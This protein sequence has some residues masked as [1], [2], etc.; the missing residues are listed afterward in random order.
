MET[1]KVSRSEKVR[2]WFRKRSRSVDKSSMGNNSLLGAKDSSRPTNLKGSGSL[3]D[4]DSIASGQSCADSQSIINQDEAPVLSP[5]MAAEVATEGVAATGMMTPLRSERDPWRQ[6]TGYLNDDDRTLLESIHAHDNADRVLADLQE[7]IAQKEKISREKAWKITFSGRRILIRDLLSKIVKW[8][9]SFKAIG[10]IVSQIDPVHAGIPWSAVKLVLSV[11]TADQEQMGLIVVGLEQVV[12]L[13]S[14]CSIYHQLYL[15]NPVQTTVSQS[16]AIKKLSDAMAYL[17]A[18]IFAFLA[19][20]IRLTDINTGARILKAF[21]QPGEVSERLKEIATLETRVTTEANLCEGTS[22]Q[23]VLQRL[24]D[25]SQDTR[26]K[27]KN[28][29]SQFDGAM[30]GLWKQLNEEERC[31][32]LQWV[33]DIPHESDH[34]VARK[35]RVDGTGDWLI[36]HEVYTTW[37]ESK[38][39]ALLWL[40][41]IPGAGK[42]KL[43]SRVID[44]LLTTLPCEPG[45]N[46]GFAYFYCDRNRADH[47]EPVA[48]MR[49]LVRQLC[50]P[51]DHPSIES[52]VEDQYLKRKVKGFS[53]DR[54]VA[55]DCKQLLLQLVA[56]YHCVYIVVDGLDECDRG[57]RHILMD[58]LDEMVE[59]FE[60]SVKIYIASRTDQD[61]RNRYHNGT[62]LEVTA[63]D[64]QAD[65]EKYILKKMEQSN[66][67]QKRLY[68]KLRRKILRTFQ[69]KS[70]GMFQWATLHIGELLQLERNADIANYLDG[71]PK[72]LEAAY[73]KIY[74]QISNQIGSKRDIAFA[75]FKVVMA[76]R[77]PLH[78]F[79]LAIAVAQHPSHEFIL[80]QDVDIAYVLEACQNL[81]IFTDGSE[82]RG[83]ASEIKKE[84]YLGGYL[85]KEV[86][87]IRSSPAKVIWE[88]KFGVTKDSI[89]RFAHLSVQEYLE[90]KHWSSTEAHDFLAGIC[91]R[92]LLCLSLPGE[93]ERGGEVDCETDEEEDWGAAVVLRV[94]EFERRR[95][96]R[97]IPSED[98]DQEMAAESGSLEKGSSGVVGEVSS[99][100]DSD[101][102]VSDRTQRSAISTGTRP[103]FEPPPF[104]CYMELVNPHSHDDNQSCFSQVFQPY[105]EGYEGSPLEAWTLYC[106]SSLSYHNAHHCTNSERTSCYSLISLMEQFLGT[107]SESTTSYKAWIHL[108]QNSFYLDEY[109]RELRD[110]VES[111]TTNLKASNFTTL[112]ALTRP[113]S[114][115]VFGLITLGLD[116]VLKSWL[117]SGKL[118]PNECNNQGDSL[119]YLAILCNEIE[120][121]KI[122]LKHGADP[123]LPGSSVFTP[124]GLAVNRK[125]VDFVR[126]LAE[127]GADLGATVLSFGKRPENWR[128]SRLPEFDTPICEA[129]AGGDS[130]IV[131]ALLDVA[132]STSYHGK[133]LQLGRALE[134]AAA[135]CR[136]DLIDILVSHWKDYE[137]SEFQAIIHGSLASVPQTEQGIE[138]MKLLI[139]RMKGQ[140]HGSL[141]HS[142][143]TNGRWAFAE[144]LVSTGFDVNAQRVD[145]LRE[146]P[147]HSIFRSGCG[148]ELVKARKLLEW[149]A[150]VD[151]RDIRG[152]TPLALAMMTWIFDADED[153]NDDVVITPAGDVSHVGVSANV[154][155][156]TE[157]DNSLVPRL[158]AIRQLLQHGADPNAVNSDGL[159]SLG[160]ACV[161][162]TVTPEVIQLLLDHDAVVNAMQGNGKVTMSPLDI[163]HLHDE[164]SLTEARPEDDQMTKVREILESHGAKLLRLDDYSRP[165]PLLQ[166]VKNGLN[167]GE[168]TTGYLKVINGMSQIYQQLKDNGRNAWVQGKDANGLPA[169]YR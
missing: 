151:A 25:G 83:I 67:C 114:K 66:F 90:T 144:A 2:R 80:D 40:N 137:E 142:A 117:D 27:L 52:C 9:D 45:D 89:C 91:L 65:I 152:N 125:E 38:Q 70:Q 41:G 140:T 12:C 111:V 127:S 59:K 18:R 55:E 50:V 7:S 58:L 146:T 56:G 123:N 14:R 42:T 124:L 72:G 167:W 116:E 10:D 106:A 61:L 6:A 163:L 96:I 64:N 69:E 47:N 23:S 93:T 77:R 63:N 35:E 73:D 155:T 126:L 164:P 130:N 43:S 115:P 153:D 11:L 168:S 49:S 102:S 81:L 22:T 97:I 120:A 141:L 53:S 103:R 76:S 110:P 20:Y 150:D 113:Y 48:I 160:L 62:Y 88:H 86:D 30:A 108:D 37:R 132:G 149:G 95:L 139:R 161:H 145:W 15:E 98:E 26:Q 32:I 36:S 133:P 105:L 128:G 166:S 54:L 51:R 112:K 147:L 100:K 158:E 131:K 135:E 118:D 136:G 68:P 46:I 107:P 4:T 101:A 33:S 24:E 159:S 71:L 21:C 39:S 16:R 60:Q 74:D 29:I 119:L 138:V 79:E 17:Y 8:L 34:Y 82:E 104:N 109:P 19:Y 156:T 78:P 57:T 13:I 1:T 169:Y 44:D 154:V 148:D 5:A 94:S 87:N 28:I 134:K 162:A 157:Q 129:V 122:L 31:K 85:Y 75:A 121:C 92:T 3:V 84:P 99:G 143:I 165:V